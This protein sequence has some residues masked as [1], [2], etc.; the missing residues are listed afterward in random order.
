M[1]FPL[2]LTTQAYVYAMDEFKQ[3]LKVLFLDYIGSFVQSPYLGSQIGIHETDITLIKTGAQATVEQ[4]PGASLLDC[5][6]RVHDGHKVTAFL[7]VQYR[8]NIIDF[9]FDVI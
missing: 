3:T 6:V 7:Q 1:D 4:I 2:D 8:G 9:K 5:T